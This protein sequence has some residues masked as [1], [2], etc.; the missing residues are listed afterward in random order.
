MC[1]KQNEQKIVDNKNK[2]IFKEYENVQ[3]IEIVE[4]TYEKNVL[5]YQEDGKYGLLSFSGNTITEAKY[6]E[7]STT[8]FKEGELFVKQD[9]KFGIIDKNGD[10]K[11]KNKYDEIQLDEYYTDEEKIQEAV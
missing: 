3:V 2:E 6:E 11:I 5:V 4:G 10:Y 7:I 8:G 1:K 9:G